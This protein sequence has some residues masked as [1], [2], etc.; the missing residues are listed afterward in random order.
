MQKLKRRIREVD[1]VVELAFPSMVVCIVIATAPAFAL[2]PIGPSRTGFYEVLATVCATALIAVMI[3]SRNIAP[4]TLS[5][6]RERA[7][8]LLGLT[9]GL[10]LSIGAS[11]VAIGI[12]HGSPLLFGVSTMSG[13]TTMFLLLLAV[14]LRAAEY[15]ESADDIAGM[16]DGA[17]DDSTSI[18]PVVYD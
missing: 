16:L 8:L 11:L 10:L 15:G 13:A 6:P 3:D 4:S 2:L 7:G 5:T 18:D 12:G 1:R 14:T 9:V 17:H